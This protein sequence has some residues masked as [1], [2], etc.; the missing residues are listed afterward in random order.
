MA[1]VE[2]KHRMSKKKTESVAGSI[3]INSN[4]TKVVIPP[5]KRKPREK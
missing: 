3:Y 4:G 1:K 2:R 5:Y